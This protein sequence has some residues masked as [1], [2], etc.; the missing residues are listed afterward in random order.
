MYERRRLTPLCTLLL[1][2]LISLLAMM[3]AYAFFNNK[4]RAEDEIGGSV[5]ALIHG[6]SAYFP[7]LKSD[8]SAQIEGDLATITVVQTFLNP[9]DKVLNATYLFPLN[10]DAAV[11]FMMMETGDER[12][13]AVI[14]K[15]AQARAIYD[16]AKSEGKAAALL[17]QHRPNMFTQELANL[18]PG[19]P[20]IITL[21]YSMAVP[22][23]DGA[24]ELVVPLVVGPRFVPQPKAVARPVSNGETQGPAKKSGQWSFGKVPA[25]PM[26]GGLTIPDTIEKDRVSLHIDLKSAV[27]L[28]NIK[29][30]THKLVVTG[31]DR[32]KSIDLASGRTIDNKDFVLRYELYGRSVEAGLLAHHDERGHFFS[33]LVEPPNAPLEKDITPREMVFVLDTS[34]SMMG[35]PMEASK[36]FMRHAIAGLR[37]RDYFR[38]IRFSDN[39]GEFAARP[40]QAT[41]LNKI[42]GLKYVNSL[43]AGGG[44]QIPKAIEHAFLVPAEPGTLRIVTFLTDGYIGNEARVLQLINEKI[45]DARIYAFGVG[46][47]VNRYLL[48][49]MGRVGRGFARFIDPT[50]NV[51]KVAIELAKRLEAPL[52]TD[53]KVNWGGLKTTQVTPEIIPDLFKGDSLRIMAR[54]MDGLKAGSTHSLTIS[55]YTNGRK[56]DMPV[57][58]TVPQKLEGDRYNALPLIWARS[59]IADHMRRLSTGRSYRRKAG[60]NAQLEQAVT[61]LGLDFSLMTQWTSFVAVSEKIVNEAPQDTLDSQV[62]LNRVKGVANEAYGKKTPFKGQQSPLPNPLQKAQRQQGTRTALI[63]SRL[64]GVGTSGFVGTG[65]S[66]FGGSTAPEPATN[67]AMLLLLLMML[68]GWMWSKRRRA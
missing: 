53:I 46:S 47:S 16:M 41:T 7:T 5:R 51:N 27:T 21:K 8:I 66:G 12:I 38:I 54:A 6:K 34:G 61:K 19:Q 24:Y 9:S 32:Q 22:R 3:D 45:G 62:P 14:K 15:K 55:G 59:T 10:K 30:A 1:A 37:P 48:A 33:L 50:E 29:S 68:S 31:D 28:K 49:E 56:A 42:A 43:M 20:V 36:T 63:T 39:T 40:V 64:Q 2:F 57:H 60:A 65:P 13:T 52:L 25:Y 23:I 67:A 35:M 44:T 18:M 4:V 17:S 58:F 26:V 11:S